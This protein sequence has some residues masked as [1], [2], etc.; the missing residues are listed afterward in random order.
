MDKMEY[1]EAQV[2]TNKSIFIEIQLLVDVS[3][4]V[5][6]GQIEK[7]NSGIFENKGFYLDKKYNW[8][9]VIDDKNQ[10]VLVPLRKE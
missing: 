2:I 4:F 5:Y 6:Y 7:R 10:L 1:P 8:V 3:D 9:V